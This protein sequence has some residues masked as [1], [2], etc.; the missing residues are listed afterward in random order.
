VTKEQ[1]A[2]VQFGRRRILPKYNYMIQPR[3]QVR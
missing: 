1:K 3:T 2:Q